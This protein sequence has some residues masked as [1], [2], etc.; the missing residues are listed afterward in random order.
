MSKACEYE[1]E[2]LSGNVGS[3]SAAE[4]SCEGYNSDVSEE[5]S[6]D[7]DP[8]PSYKEGCG[9]SQS[10]AEDPFDYMYTSEEE[11]CTNSSDDS[12]DKDL[13]QSTLQKLNCY[14]EHCDWL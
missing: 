4:D 2:E 8:R 11:S 5:L 1:E 14:T 10:A 13:T 7:I 3:L 12:D 6:G 9:T